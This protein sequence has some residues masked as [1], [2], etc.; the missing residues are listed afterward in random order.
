MDP[1]YRPCSG[2]ISRN[3]PTSS[4]DRGVPAPLL[5]PNEGP[6]R[7]EARYLGLRTQQA[8][9]RPW[10]LTEVAVA[11]SDLTDSSSARRASP[12]GSRIGRSASPAISRA[13]SETTPARVIGPGRFVHVGVCGCRLTDIAHASECGAPTEDAERWLR[14]PLLSAR[15]VGSV[16]SALFR[17][18]TARSTSISRGGG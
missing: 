7:V 9:D 15:C 2:G 1:L 8:A 17:R 10:L 18:S 6:L 14:R 11:V 3:A 5:H 13:H 12:T 16:R 4:R